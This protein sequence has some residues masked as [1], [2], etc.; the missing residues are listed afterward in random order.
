MA[1]KAGTKKAVGGPFL[2]L[3][4]ICEHVITEGNKV[5]TLVR[6]VDKFTIK[7]DQ[8]KLPPGTLMPRVVVCF[9]SGDAKGVFDLRIIGRDP[10]GKKVNEARSK[11]KLEGGVHG[12]MINTQIPL[13]VKTIGLYWFDVYLNRR[14]ITS[15]PLEVRYEK[16]DLP[17]AT[18]AP[19]KKTKKAAKKRPG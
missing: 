4:L 14:L 10:S 19:K 5:N 1:K 7:S 12:A 3:A 11:L 17:A 18:P 6:I 13:P 9:K 15:A 2:Q 8:D 16:I